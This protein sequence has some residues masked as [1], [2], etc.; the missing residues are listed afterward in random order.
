MVRPM[1]QCCY[2]IGL[3]KESASLTCDLAVAAVCLQDIAWGTLA[4]EG[5]W[6]VDAE[7]TAHAQK[8]VC[9]LVNSRAL[10]NVN[11]GVSVLGKLE[12]RGAVTSLHKGEY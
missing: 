8:T 6:R 11:T 7:V 5:A 4:L 12:T 1:Q 9:T 2:H 3:G 10:V